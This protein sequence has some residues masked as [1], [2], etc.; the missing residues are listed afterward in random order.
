MT[1]VPLPSGLIVDMK[2]LKAR[3]FRYIANEEI[4]Q[5]DETEDYVLESTSSDVVDP[6]PYKF[7]GAKVDWKK[8][9]V[10]DGAY[11]FLSVRHLCYPDEPYVFKLYCSN[12]L[13]KRSTREPFEVEV[14][15]GQYLREK[16]KRLSEEDRDT[17]RS[18]NVFKSTIPG[19]DKPF[20]FRLRT[21]EEGRRFG[22]LLKQIRGSGKKKKD[23]FNLPVS[24]LAFSMIEVGGDKLDFNKKVALIED[25][26]IGDFDRLVRIVTKDHDCGVDTGV[27]DIQCPDCGTPRVEVQLPFDRSFLLPATTSH[28]RARSKTTIEEMASA[29]DDDPTAPATS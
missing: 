13:C 22:A 15:I 7:D 2:R 20:S 29:G 24:S 10:G 11:A 21:R 27:E 23:A 19:I 3:D 8:A 4:A 12:R 5:N 14:D 17:F 1:H 18:G 16:S 28:G 6:G 9:L 26:D 25:L